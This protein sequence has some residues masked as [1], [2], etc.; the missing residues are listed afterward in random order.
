MAFGNGGRHCGVILIVSDDA[1]Q[2]VYPWEIA[3][4]PYA[5]IFERLVRCC[6]TAELVGHRGKAAPGWLLRTHR[7][8]AEKGHICGKWTHIS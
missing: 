1:F 6:R 7:R 3:V 8:P 4:Q 2:G 5:D